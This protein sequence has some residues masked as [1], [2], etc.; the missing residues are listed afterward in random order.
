MSDSLMDI[1]RQAVLAALGQRPTAARRRAI[2]EALRQLGEEQERLADADERVGHTVRR[3]QLE[4]VASSGRRGGRP[5]GSGARFVRVE[6]PAAPGRSWNVYVGTAVYQDVGEP[7]RLDPQ[8]IGGRVWLRP[9]ETGGY[10]VTK[11]G[12]SIGHF[13]VGASTIEALGLD[14]GR[15]ATEIRAGAIVLLGLLEEAS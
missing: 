14:E 13:S 3:A 1:L 11:P 5:K 15:Y 7:E 9:V 4:Q 8:L 6:V 12:R 10:K 2:A